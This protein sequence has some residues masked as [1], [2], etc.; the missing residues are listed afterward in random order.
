MKRLETMRTLCWMLV[1]FL[2]GVALASARGAAQEGEPGKLDT[3]EAELA[4]A[5]SLRAALRKAPAPQRATL[6]REA[7][8]AFRAVRTHFPQERAAAAE[9]AFRAGELLRADEPVAA[10]AEFRAAREL[11]AGTAF[12]ARAGL[13]LGHL[14]RRE[15]ALEAAL[16]DYQSVS[17]EDKAERRYRDDA[18]LWAGRVCADLGRKDEARRIW[19][20]VAAAAESPLDRIEAFDELVLALVDAGDLEGAAGMLERCKTTLADTANE[21]TQLGERVRNALV[22]MR[23]ARRLEEA[24]ARRTK[25]VVIEKKP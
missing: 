4:R 11:G 12:A 6:Q 7:V 18:L 24:V 16:G 14:H 23:A 9:A 22:R 17:A 8:A 19:E 1:L 15:G 10:E 25:G 5:Q 3:A 21:E 20:G 13:E 2:A